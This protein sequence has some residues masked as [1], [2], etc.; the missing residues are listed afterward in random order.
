[1]NADSYDPLVKRLRRLDERV[2]ELEFTAAEP[3]G[4]EYGS[5]D[6]PVKHPP[7]ASFGGDAPNLPWLCV[8]SKRMQGAT[9]IPTV[10]VM[11]GPREVV[12]GWAEWCA[13]ETGDYWELDQPESGDWCVVVRYKHP[14]PDWA[15]GGIIPGAWV[16]SPAT[17]PEVVEGAPGESGVRDDAE[18]RVFVLAHYSASGA[19]LRQYHAGMLTATPILDRAACLNPPASL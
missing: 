7:T 15:N 17:A 11:P 10:R 16:G 6:W 3:E 5:G 14:T 2:Q 9:E 13:P 18:Y 19:T 12:G 8:L 4:I 1:M